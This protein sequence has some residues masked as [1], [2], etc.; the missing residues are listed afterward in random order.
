MDL[1]RNSEDVVTVS[2]S[3]KNLEGLL[4]QLDLGRPDAVIQ[5][6]VGATSGRSAPSQTYGESH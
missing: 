4:G 3:R 5:R 6:L 1:L 2:L